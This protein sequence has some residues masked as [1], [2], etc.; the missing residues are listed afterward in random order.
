[1]NIQWR[2]QNGVQQTTILMDEEL[3]VNLIAET[4]GTFTLRKLLHI[5]CGHVEKTDDPYYN[6]N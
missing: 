6:G 4:G 5:I 1:V 2:D 3:D